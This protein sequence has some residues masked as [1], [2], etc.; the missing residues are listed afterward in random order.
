MVFKKQMI[1][2]AE[3]SSIKLQDRK[4]KAFLAYS[5]MVKA[6]KWYKK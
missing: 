3:V 1:K 4:Q 5:G 6:Y 2:K